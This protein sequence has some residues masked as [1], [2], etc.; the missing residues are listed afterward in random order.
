MGQETPKA[1]ILLRS[2]PEVKNSNR[3]RYSGRTE[4]AGTLW[5]PKQ[6]PL[7]VVESGKGL[8]KDDI[9]DDGHFSPAQ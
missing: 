9:Q 4:Q 8:R 6:G 7:G 1:G 5:K 3:I 2:S